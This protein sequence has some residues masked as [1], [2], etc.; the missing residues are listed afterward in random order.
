VAEIRRLCQQSA[1]T[2]AADPNARTAATGPPLLYFAAVLAV[3]TVRIMLLSSGAKE[4]RTPDL[5]H[6][7]QALYQLS[8]SPGIAPMPVSM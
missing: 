1:P 6:A 5:L 2:E 4:I 3:R 8:Y 7:M